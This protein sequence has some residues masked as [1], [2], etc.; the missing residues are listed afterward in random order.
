MKAFM[1][2]LIRL[3]TPPF[4]FH[5]A[6]QVAS[7]VVLPFRKWRVH[8]SLSAMSP[9]FQ[10]M[11][12]GT[13]SRICQSSPL[14]TQLLEKDVKRYAEFGSGASTLWFM[15]KMSHDAEIV[16]VESSAQWA[17]EMG[18]LLMKN[19]R[20]GSVNHV[21]LGTVSG[22]G[23]PL[24]YSQKDKIIEYVELP[25]RAEKSFDLVYID[26][27]FRV[28]CFL[29]SV[30]SSAPGTRIVFDDYNNRTWYH[31]VED[32]LHPVSKKGKQALFIRPERIDDLKIKAL[33][34]AF[35]MVRD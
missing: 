19:G 20:K 26:G 33:R 7:R 21:D 22:W 8:S 23:V 15:E 11:L 31:V 5:F 28:A 12:M 13:Y 32:I 27:V 18:M 16:S 14:L 4:L 35:L 6:A 3:S 30:L 34:D 10:R 17:S 2:E 9:P 24:G 1:S 25:F 29:T